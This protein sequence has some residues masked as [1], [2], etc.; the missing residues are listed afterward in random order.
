V[1]AHDDKKVAVLQ[2]QIEKLCARSQKLAGYDD[3]EAMVASSAGGAAAVVEMDAGVGSRSSSDGR[4]SSGVGGSSSASLQSAAAPFR[5][6]TAPTAV[7]E[8][9]EHGD[10]D[11]TAAFHSSKLP[12]AAPFRW[13][14]ADT[15]AAAALMTRLKALESIATFVLERAVTTDEKDSPAMALPLYL[16]AADAY[17]KVLAAAKEARTSGGP[18]L[19]TPEAAASGEEEDAATVLARCQKRL[20]SI[21][22]RAE[23]IKRQYKSQGATL[24]S[25]PVSAAGPGPG[26]ATTKPNRAS[27]GVAA[28]SSSSV[29]SGKGGGGGFGG[30]GS[31]GGSGG[32]GSG[33]GGDHS[34]ESLS[35]EEIAVLRISSHIN[36]KVYLPWQDTDIHEDFVFAEPFTDPD[37]R[38][39]L[40]EKQTRH[41]GGWR[42]PEQYVR[43]VADPVMIAC[44]S[45][46]AITQDNVGDCSFVS[47][48]CMA[49]AYE[50]KFRR[51]LLTNIIYPQDR[52]GR[53]IYNPSG[54]YIVRLF[55]GGI[56]RKVVVDDELPV[57]KHGRLLCARTTR[58]NELWVSI[59]EKAYMKVNG[60]YDFPG[61]TACIDMHALTGWIP[62]SVKL[63]GTGDRPL[64]DAAGARARVEFASAEGHGDADRIWQRLHSASN[65]GDCLVSI[66]TTPL[67]EDQEDRYGLVSGHAYAVLRVV[68]LDGGLRLLKVKNPWCRVR[69]KGRYAPGDTKRWT[70]RLRQALQYDPEAAVQQDNGIF[71]MDYDAVRRFFATMHLNWNPG[72]FRFRRQVHGRWA[73]DAPGPKSDRYSIFDNPQ[74]HLD[75]LASGDG[76]AAGSG[77]GGGG[78]G[79][80]SSSSES[81]AR[82]QRKTLSVWLLLWRH[83]LAKERDSD[84]SV[85]MLAVH[86]YHSDG[87]QRKLYAKAA[88]CFSEGVYSN[89]PHRLLRLDLRHGRDYAF[90]VVVSQLRRVADLN[91][92]LHTFC[93][94]A[95]VQLRKLHNT[96]A[97]EV[98]ATGEWVLG[99]TAVGCQ[100]YGRFWQNPQFVFDVP[101]QQ[102]AALFVTAQEG[103]SVGVSVYDLAAVPDHGGA[104]TGGGY[105]FDERTGRITKAYVQSHA[106]SGDYQHSFCVCDL[107]KLR[108]GRYVCVV[109]TFQPNLAGVFRLALKLGK[110]GMASAVRLRPL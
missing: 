98:T 77:G 8:S 91:F 81:V 37:G 103:L 109:S 11:T 76:D 96:F 22:E 57:D 19:P 99:A 40:A 5:W 63:V 66:S 75:I 33:S 62:E 10:A 28:S 94:T 105:A 65:F 108:K 56:A 104:T 102:Q 4:G 26:N 95:P 9:P 107:P 47:S 6:V 30:G 85:P 13:E 68:E 101:S 53:P 86:A 20:A 38:L 106:S 97:S 50:R 71:W 21:V 23:S 16:K 29:G 87:R 110:P 25:S 51:P 48:L 79:G 41:F 44:V 73:K 72:L 36:G 90:T 1:E 3:E 31:G 18:P 2:G 74:Y 80:G 58:P 17:M 15:A 32:G 54:K 83:Q 61:S 27:I 100:N 35:D 70:P 24:S 46:T 59:V 55:V 39:V 14:S 89:S 88:K 92:T 82:S 69:W 93:S 64:E 52:A 67:S 43:S 12:T 60:G 34:G 49:A 7:P 84:E 78:G 42:R 45:A